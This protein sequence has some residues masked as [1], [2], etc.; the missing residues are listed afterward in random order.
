MSREDKNTVYPPGNVEIVEL[1]IDHNGNKQWF[2]NSRDGWV[3][4]GKDNILTLNA[5]HFEVGTK[6]ELTNPTPNCES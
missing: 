2:G 1:G 3:E 4:V 6:I 5:E